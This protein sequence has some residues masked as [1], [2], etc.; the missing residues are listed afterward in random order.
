MKETIAN[1]QTLNALK[2]A[3]FVAKRSARKASQYRESFNGVIN[4]QDIQY[5]R[6][7]AVASEFYPKSNKLFTF[8]LLQ[9]TLCIS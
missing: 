7:H 4:K 2:I 3:P 5:N 1:P 8:T 9:Y 6:L